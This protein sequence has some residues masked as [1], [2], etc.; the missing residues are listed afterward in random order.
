M[1]PTKFSPPADDSQKKQG[2]TSHPLGGISSKPCFPLEAVEYPIDRPRSSPSQRNFDIYRRH[3][4]GARAV[5]LAIQYG[6]SWQRIYQIVNQVET[7]IEEH[8]VRKQS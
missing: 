2:F 4:S 6:I 1:N 3:T 8:S 7:Y 5:D